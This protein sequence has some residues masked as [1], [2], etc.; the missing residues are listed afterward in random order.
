MNSDI[1]WKQRFENFER[2][3]NVLNRTLLINSPSEAEKGGIIQFFEISFELAWKVLKDYIENN[4]EIVKSPRETLR[5]AYDTELIENG[6][7]WLDGLD[8]RNLSTHAYDEVQIN[9]IITR[10][11][12]IYHPELNALYLTFQKII[13]EQ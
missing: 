4:G 12:N 5:K 10:I 13:N 1:R 11:R 2:A 3:L 6:K 9:Q 8:D 7:A